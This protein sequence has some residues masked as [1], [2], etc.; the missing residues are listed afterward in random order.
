MGKHFLLTP[1]AKVIGNFSNYRHFQRKHWTIPEND[2]AIKKINCCLVE[3]SRRQNVAGDWFF[4]V[5]RFIMPPNFPRVFKSLKQICKLP[6][7]LFMDSNAKKNQ[8]N[9]RWNIYDEDD[10][11][12]WFPRQP[13]ASAGWFACGRPVFQVALVNEEEVEVGFWDSWFQVKEARI[14]LSM[15]KTLVVWETKRRGP[16]SSLRVRL[17]L[18]M[19]VLSNWNNWY[20]TRAEGG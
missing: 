4:L 9:F 1:E 15:L 17:Q 13:P 20:Q 2:Y 12:W 5:T 18:T 16:W 19:A 8:L 10:G 7:N 11:E 6:K 3:G 14:F